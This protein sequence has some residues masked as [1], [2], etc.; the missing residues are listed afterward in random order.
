MDSGG[1]ALLFG[2][3]GAD[4]ARQRFSLRF[5]SVLQ[6]VLADFR[7]QGIAVN[8]ELPGRGALV[9]VGAIECETDHFAF[10]NLNGFF[11]EDV[12]AEQMVYQAFKFFFHARSLPLVELHGPRLTSPA[13]MSCEN[14]P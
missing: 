12:T 4:F 9:T 7:E 1:G 10:E 13:H 5:A 3:S 14:L 2:P 6:T 11:E 8:A